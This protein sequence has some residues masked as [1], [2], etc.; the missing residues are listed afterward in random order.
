MKILTLLRHAK[1]GWD[2]AITR[3]FDRPINER[4]ER[5]A[6]AMGKHAASL[7]LKPDFIVASP[8]VRCTD[9]LDYFLPAAQ[10]ADLE[11]LWDRR[12]YLASSATLADVLRELPD[13][14]HHVLLCGHNP[15]MEDMVFDLVPANEGDHSRQDVEEKFPTAAIA[16]I[17]LAI[18]HWADLRDNVGTLKTFIRPRDIDPNLGPASH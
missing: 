13:S 16:T 10:L 1:S 14:A 2:D 12:V 7:G 6:A 4:G 18:D 5:A 3:D 15:S 8:A 9:T 17:E 11:P